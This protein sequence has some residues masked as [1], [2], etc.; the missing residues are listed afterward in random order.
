MQPLKFHGG[1]IM[2][3]EGYNEE[4]LLSVCSS[5][6][7]SS[8]PIRAV[9][10]SRITFRIRIR[11]DATRE[12]QHF[13]FRRDFLDARSPGLGFVGHIVPDIRCW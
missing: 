9:V 1:K 13:A 6:D 10:P 2:G 8:C 11:I 5:A 4:V 7:P 3:G 12:D